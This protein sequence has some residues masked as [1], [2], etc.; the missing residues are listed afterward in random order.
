MADFVYL[1]P[2]AAISAEHPLFN[3]EAEIR[4]AALQLPEKYAWIYRLSIAD[5][6]VPELA[7]AQAKGAIADCDI[8]LASELEKA[9][10]LV[11]VELIELQAK[12]KSFLEIAAEHF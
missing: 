3:L 7:K 6:K 11:K 1:K 12:K 8:L 4:I 5:D 2:A 9:K 10:E